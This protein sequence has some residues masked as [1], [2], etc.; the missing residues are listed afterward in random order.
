MLE[1]LIHQVGSQGN[2]KAVIDLAATEPT[3]P[4]VCLEW[5][6]PFLG[7]CFNDHHLNA[8]KHQ[9]VRQVFKQFSV[10]KSSLFKAEVQALMAGTSNDGKKTVVD[11]GAP[12]AQGG[13]KK[14][15]MRQQMVARL[16]SAGSSGAKGDA[17]AGV[18]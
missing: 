6:V 5:G 4:L 8:L 10:Q 18:Q 1:G 16:E 13:G 14:L 7:V 2:I 11:L 12:S 9:L 17:N 3:L 15:T